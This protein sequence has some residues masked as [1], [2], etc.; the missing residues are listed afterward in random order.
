MNDTATV[1]VSNVITTIRRM[2]DMVKNV[3]VNRDLCIQ[4]VARIEPFASILIVEKTL[5]PHQTFM[6]L[7]LHLHTFVEEAERFLSTFENKPTRRSDDCSPIGVNEIYPFTTSIEESKVVCQSFLKMDKQLSQIIDEFGKITTSSELQKLRNFNEQ[8][9]QLI[10]VQ[11]AKEL[12]NDII[13]EVNMINS[14]LS[15][16]GRMPTKTLQE[17]FGIC[18]VLS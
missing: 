3:E 13:N 4:M 14:R 10:V 5:R 9:P 15:M 8:S 18:Q 17:L 1:I 11:Y 6:T 7:V 16:G 12:Q 2:E